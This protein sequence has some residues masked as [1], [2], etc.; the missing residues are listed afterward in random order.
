[1]CLSR[2]AD[3]DCEVQE[4]GYIHAYKVVEFCEDKDGYFGPCLTR[5]E[6]SIGENQANSSPYLI[7]GVRKEESYRPGFH[8][9]VSVNDYKN[10]WLGDEIYDNDNLRL[11]KVRIKPEDIIAKGYED[12]I[13]E[14][15]KVLVAIS[16]TIDSFEECD[17]LL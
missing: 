11:I 9:F 1:M 16:M 8:C 4:D 12:N 14:F 3:F 2:L 7:L 10:S 6:Y 17:V 13:D 15:S 5:H